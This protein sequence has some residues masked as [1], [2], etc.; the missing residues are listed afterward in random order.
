AENALHLVLIGDAIVA[1]AERLEL[2]D[3]GAGDERLAAG[4][5]KHSCAQPFFP[6]DLRTSLA[7]LLVHPPSHGVACHRPVE[8]HRGDLAI[9]NV[10]HLP[11]G[12][13]TAPTV[14][15]AIFPI[16]AACVA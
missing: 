7:E 10:A 13:R 14:A 2:R 3:V 9:A 4:T 15:T 6:A 16:T 11:I 5:A 1:T 12:H 8:D